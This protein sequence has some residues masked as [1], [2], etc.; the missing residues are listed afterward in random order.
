MFVCFLFACLLAC[1][2]ACLF[3]CLFVCFVLFCFVWLFVCLSGRLVGRWVLNHYAL[4]FPARVKW[5]GQVSFEAKKGFFGTDPSW[6]VPQSSAKIQGFP[7]H[8]FGQVS[9]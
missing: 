8:V 7:R 5:A 6:K 4:G 3:V 1:L 9:A 2:L